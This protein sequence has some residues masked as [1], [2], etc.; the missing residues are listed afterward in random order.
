MTPDEE[1]TAKQIERLEKHAENTAQSIKYS[2]ERFDIL[3][4]SLSSAGI[5]LC[6]SFAKDT[7]E[8]CPCINTML[9]K[10][11]SAL[12]GIAIILNLF[13]QVTSYVACK[14]EIQAV[15]N[16]IREKKNKPMIGNQDAFEKNKGS[17]NTSTLILNFAC[18]ISLICAMIFISVFMFN[19]L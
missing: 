4:I 18:L 8:I 9:L 3:I 6:A 13:S 19:K 10:I 14:N 1:K 2:V 7:L 17:F 16:I 11:S 15:K 12:F 5:A